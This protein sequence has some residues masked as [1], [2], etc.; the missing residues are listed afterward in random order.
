MRKII[1]LMLAVASVLFA[2]PFNTISANTLGRGN[3][4]IGP[5]IPVSLSLTG[6]T[7]FA[8]TPLLYIG[9]GL[10]DVFDVTLYGGA[11]IAKSVDSTGAST[12]TGD[13]AVF[14]VQPKFEVLKSEI[15]TLSPTFGLVIP[16]KNGAP[17]GVNPGFLT[18]FD[19]SPLNLHANLYYN[20]VF[21]GSYGTV[22][23]LAA[24]DFWVTNNFSIFAELNAYYSL[25]DKELTLEAWPGLCYYPIDMLSICASCGIPASLDYITPGLA[26]YVN[27]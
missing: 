3:G 16:F 15:V 19:F 25:D 12:V 24:P 5:Y 7:G 23:F 8:T 14:V 27:F 17:V 6:E 2:D 4:Y 18:S 1:F 13:D 11:T 22:S 10:A 21:D 9:I 20:L 26:L